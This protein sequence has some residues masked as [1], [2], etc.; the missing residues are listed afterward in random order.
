V[1]DSDSGTSVQSLSTLPYS[2]YHHFPNTSTLGG[3]KILEFVPIM[4]KQITGQKN[5]FDVEKKFGFPHLEC[6]HAFHFCQRA[7]KKLTPPL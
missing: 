5:A 2:A 4:Q 7:K 1:P 3:E 6:S